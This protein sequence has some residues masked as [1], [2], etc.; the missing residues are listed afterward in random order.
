[1]ANTNLNKETLISLWQKMCNEVTEETLLEKSGT[2][3]EMS[4]SLVVNDNISLM[5]F[6][7]TIKIIFGNQ[8]EY[9]SEILSKEEFDSLKELFYAAEDK[10]EKMKKDIIISRGVKAL[11]DL[12][13]EV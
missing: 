11:S 7:N 6:N 13:A 2:A 5:L 1:M 10:I 12:L 9:V 4:F 3:T 8:I